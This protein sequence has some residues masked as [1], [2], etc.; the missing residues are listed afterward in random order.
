MRCLLQELG[1]EQAVS[2]VLYEDNQGAITWT[3]TGV[4]NARHVTIR[5]NYVKEQVETG[6]V[7]MQYL[8]TSMMTA[9]IFTKPMLRV[10]F[11]KHRLA[12]G[13]LKH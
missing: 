13:I 10:S 12:L 9:D 7:E 1:F 6:A 2:M 8:P 3:T 5:R 11:E 4:R